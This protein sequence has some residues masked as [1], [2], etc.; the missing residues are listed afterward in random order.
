V[1]F[2]RALALRRLAKACIAARL[3]SRIAR[4]AAAT[5]RAGR[6]RRVAS[7]RAP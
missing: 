5:S 4:T 6:L 3:S 1:R 7:I 2:A